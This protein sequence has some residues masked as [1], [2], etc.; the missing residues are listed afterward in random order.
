MAVL[1]DGQGFSS[2]ENSTMFV[3]ERANGRGGLPRRLGAGLMTSSLGWRR[4]VRET[5]GRA[6]ESKVEDGFEQFGAV[7][8]VLLEAVRWRLRQITPEGDQR[9]FRQGLEGFGK[10]LPQVV[11]ACPLAPGSGTQKP[12]KPAVPHGL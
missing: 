12:R 2:Q 3:P 1:V 5:R 11:S 4:R 9:L 10:S 7:A 8:D 6:L